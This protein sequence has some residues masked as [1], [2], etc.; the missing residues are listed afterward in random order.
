MDENHKNGYLKSNWCKNDSFYQIKVC[1][2]DYLVLIK[3]LIQHMIK[4]IPVKFGWAELVARFT[5]SKF[6]RGYAI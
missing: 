4:A 2:V 5:D 6:R 1:M 3:Q